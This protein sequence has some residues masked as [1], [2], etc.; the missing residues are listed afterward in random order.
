VLDKIKAKTRQ[1]SGQPKTLKDKLA[2][3]SGFLPVIEGA[4]K[5]TYQDKYQMI[6]KNREKEKGSY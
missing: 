4:K 3:R 5:M 2:G 6:K 1:K